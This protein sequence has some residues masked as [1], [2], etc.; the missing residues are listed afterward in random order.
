MSVPIL[1]DYLS[2][3]FNTIINNSYGPLLHALPL[4]LAHKSYGMK[5][6]PDLP[7]GEEGDEM[8]QENAEIAQEEREKGG[9][10]LPPISQPAPLGGQPVSPTRKTAGPSPT[11]PNAPFNKA[12]AI[13]A[14]GEEDEDDVQPIT[15]KEKT[16]PTDFNHPSTYEP[17]RTIW[18]AQDELGVAL[19]EA[20]ALHADGIDV[21]MEHAVMNEKGKVAIDGRPPN[22][23]I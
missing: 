2:A 1:T 10:P 22:G 16:A 7:S 19:Q 23:V 21:S 12:K 18:M 15:E 9:K 20:K 4:T 11:D 17:Q 3:G 13:E 6:E 5:Q 14:N 8:E